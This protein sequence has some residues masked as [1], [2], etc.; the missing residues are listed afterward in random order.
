MSIVKINALSIPPQAGEEVVKRFAART[1]ELSAVAG[2]E[3]FELLRPTGEV[4][5]RWFVYTRWADEAS[6]EAWRTSET[7]A[8]GHAG[9]PPQGDGGGH[10]QGGHGG[11]DGAEA[12]GPSPLSSGATLLEFDVTL[13]AAPPG[14]TA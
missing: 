9:G 13:S 14:A 10:P 5:E 8:R 12:S 2:F 7:F 4:E 1:G 11:Q 3:G 6:Y